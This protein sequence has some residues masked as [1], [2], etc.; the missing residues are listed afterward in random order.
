MRTAGEGADA[1][2]MASRL[3]GQRHR[4]GYDEEWKFWRGRV[5]H[6]VQHTDLTLCDPGS[7]SDARDRTGLEHVA[8]NCL[9]QSLVTS[10]ADAIEGAG[11]FDHQ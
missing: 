11:G 7:A 8:T 5:F 6:I 10:N 2:G 3:D 4:N 9:D 1:H